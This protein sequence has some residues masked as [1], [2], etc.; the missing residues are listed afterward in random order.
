MPR[1]VVSSKVIPALLLALPMLQPEK[2]QQA[3][4]EREIK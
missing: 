2:S 4:A 3:A 1:A